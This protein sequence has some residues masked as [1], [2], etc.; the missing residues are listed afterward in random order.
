MIY[1]FAQKKPKKL[2]KLKVNKKFKSIIDKTNTFA[3]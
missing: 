3:V 1:Q 2:N